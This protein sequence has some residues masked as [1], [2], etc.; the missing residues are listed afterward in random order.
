M[1]IS[2]SSSPFY[3]AW[4]SSTADDYVQALDALTSR[5]FGRLTELAESSCLKMHGVM[6]SSTP[7]MIYWR[8][9]TLACMHAIRDLRASGVPVFFTIDAGPQIKAICTEE[10]VE[11]VANTLSELPGVLNTQKIGLG[12]GAV[13][14]EHD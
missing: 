1:Q 2:E 4:V 12:G 14:V 11:Q 6:Q 5:D 10:A 3:P 7:A 13:L 8:P 9:A